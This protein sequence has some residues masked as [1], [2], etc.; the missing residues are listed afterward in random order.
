MTGDRLEPRLIEALQPF[1]GFALA[2]TLYHFFETGLFDAL[3]ERDRSTAELASAHD[4]D[5]DRLA[6]LLLFLKNEGVVEDRGG[7]FRLTARGRAFDEVRGWYTML[8]GGY[9]GTFLQMGERLAR[10]APP[11]TRDAARVGIGSCAISHHDAIPL[12]RS[13]MAR[14]LPESRPARLLDL[15]CGNAL[16]LVEFCKALPGI[17]AWG[18]E[19][20]PDGYAAAARLVEQSGLASRIRL[21]Q[22]DALDFLAGG[23][24]PA[25][26]PD[27]IVLGFVLH[28][29]LGQSGEDAVL[30]MLR[31][32]V[33]RLPEVHLVVIEVDHRA[34]DPQAMRHGLALAYYNAYYLLHPF[35]QQRLETRAFWEAL[36]ARAGLDVLACETVD[37]DVDST[38]LELGYLLRRAGA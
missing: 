28:E 2:S 9:G 30:R 10:G 11:A 22:G 33:D 18:V 20:S 15:G 37:P 27:F 26:R 19:P 34:D 5:A 4:L 8:V 14:V 25:W 6:A 1:R 13:L 23:L 12:T 16:Y 31:G 21:T 24:D 32:I 3:R 35:T 17:E 36:F 38:G 7:R 29:V